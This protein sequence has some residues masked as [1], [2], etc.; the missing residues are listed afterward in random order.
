M[1]MVNHHG[2]PTLQHLKRRVMKLDAIFKCKGL[3]FLPC[4]LRV[5]GTSMLAKVHVKESMEMLCEAKITQC[6]IKPANY[7]CI[8]MK[9]KDNKGYTVENTIAMIDLVCFVDDEGYLKLPGWIT[10]D[11]QTHLFPP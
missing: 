9:G 4:A 3:D 8:R 11:T 7:A 5:V 2:A 6:D 10:C 1:V